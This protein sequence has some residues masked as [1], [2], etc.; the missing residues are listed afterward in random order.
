MRS[1][2]WCNSTSVTFASGRRLSLVRVPLLL[3]IHNVLIIL[4]FIVMFLEAEW[5]DSMEFRKMHTSQALFTF[6][7]FSEYAWCSSSDITTEIRDFDFLLGCEHSFRRS[8]RSGTKSRNEVI[9]AN[10]N[11]RDCFRH[12]KLWSFVSIR[13]TDS[14]NWL[15][16]VM[17]RWTFDNKPKSIN[18]NEEFDCT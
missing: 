12:D 2:N 1:C 15:P 7:R 11:G 6:L 18:T 5:I 3:N 14:F 9:A 10:V 16:V 13:E 8:P 17:W 4:K